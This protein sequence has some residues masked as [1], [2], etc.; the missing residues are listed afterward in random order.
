M[1][2]QC[3]RLLCALGALTC[4]PACAPLVAMIGYNNSVVQ[5]AVQLDRIKLAGDGVSYLGSGKTITDHAVSKLAGADCRLMNVVSPDKV[6]KPNRDESAE[7]F[8][9]RMNLAAIRDEMLNGDGVAPTMAV[10]RYA[11]DG[12]EDPPVSVK[13]SAE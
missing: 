2:T 6:C 7:K 8:G 1:V 13:D 11:G 4:L 5:L 9:S 3:I 12:I 10:P